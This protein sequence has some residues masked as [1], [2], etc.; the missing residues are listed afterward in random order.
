MNG[1]IRDYCSFVANRE[2]LIRMEYERMGGRIG[3]KYDLNAAPVRSAL[4]RWKTV[5]KI[6][7]AMP[8]SEEERLEFELWLTAERIEHKEKSP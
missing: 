1:A 4:A 8:L 7:T 3:R 2:L 6:P 5:R